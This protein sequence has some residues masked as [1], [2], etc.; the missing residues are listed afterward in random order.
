MCRTAFFVIVAHAE[1][2]AAIPQPRL[3]ALRPPSNGAAASPL[4]QLEGAHVAPL[5]L[6]RPDRARGGIRGGVGLDDELE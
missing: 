6:G 5:P 2:R 4:E 1:G 3:G